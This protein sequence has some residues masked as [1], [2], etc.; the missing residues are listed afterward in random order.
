MMNRKEYKECMKKKKVIDFI[1]NHSIDIIKNMFPKK[2]DLII[3]Q[4]K[5]RRT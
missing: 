3:N 2:L 1:N 5:L 4:L